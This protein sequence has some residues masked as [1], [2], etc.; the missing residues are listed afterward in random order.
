MNT[1]NTPTSGTIINK[2]VSKHAHQ[3]NTTPQQLR[4]L[5]Y[6]L[7]IPSHQH[8]SVNQSPTT[9]Q[10][11]LPSVVPHQHQYRSQSPYQTQSSHQ[12]QVNLNVYPNST[13]SQSLY[14]Q[15][16]QTL[17]PNH[18]HS[19]NTNHS[20]TP[21][22]S[23][24]SDQ[25]NSKLRNSQQSQGHYH[26]QQQLQQAELQLSGPQTYYYSSTIPLN[27]KSSDVER[28]KVSNNQTQQLRSPFAKRPMEAP[29]TI[30]GWLHKQGSDGLMLWKK[31]WFVLSE[32]CLF[33]YKSKDFALL[34]LIIK[35]INI[36]LR[37]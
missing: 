26:P 18:F 33:Y 37:F 2:T 10:H 29:V 1:G 16:N 12:H 15:Q 27:L 20:F 6:G 22:Y 3:H 31:R 23:V 8:T 30:Q 28:K 25:H 14:T 4:L 24:N 19:Q 35:L 13:V 34:F 7:K 32:Y 21:S 11:Q 9:H 36:H 17:R 5:Q